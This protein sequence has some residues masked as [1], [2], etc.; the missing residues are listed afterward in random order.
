MASA[1]ASRDPSAKSLHVKVLSQLPEPHGV[2]QFSSLPASTTVAE[3]KTKIRDA[4]PSRPLAERQ[5]LIH[6]GR[7]AGRETDTLGEIF[8]KEAVQKEENHVFH[9]VIREVQHGANGSRQQQPLPQFYPN[10][11]QPPADLNGWQPQQ[12]LPTPFPVPTN[13]PSPNFGL[14]PPPN[15]NVQAPQSTSASRSG[16]PNALQQPAWPGISPAQMAQQ[17]MARL[18]QFQQMQQMQH[19]AA[20]QAQMQAGQ[21]ARAPTPLGQNGQSQNATSSHQQGLFA[22]SQSNRQQQP[23]RNAT[24]RPQT[25]NTENANGA[26]PT[27]A[28]ASGNMW[29][30]PAPQAPGQGMFM[31]PGMGGNFTR[32]AVGPNGQRVTMTI[33]STTNV[34]SMLPPGYSPVPQGLSGFMPP[35]ITVPMPPQ[36][37]GPPVPGFSPA[38]GPGAASAQRQPHSLSN[39]PGRPA[40]GTTNAFYGTAHAIESMRHYED[41]LRAVHDRIV[42]NPTDSNASR[43]AQASS[44]EIHLQNI[45]RLRNRAQTMINDLTIP[46]RASESARLTEEDVETLTNLNARFRRLI[47]ETQKAIDRLRG[48]LQTAQGSQGTDTQPISG[49]RGGSQS[50]STPQSS[51][52]TSSNSTQ[53]V[54][55]YLLYAPTGPHAV[56]LSPQG[57]FASGHPAPNNTLPQRGT[58]PSAT[59]APSSTTVGIAAINSEIDTQVARATAAVSN[60]NREIINANDAINLAH[61]AV[62]NLHEINNRNN[63]NNTQQSTSSGAGPQQQQQQPQANQPNGLVATPHPQQA[64]AEEDARD[65][66]RAIIYPLFRHLWLL[67]RLFGFIWFLTRGGGSRRTLLLVVATLIYCAIQ[68]GFLGDRWERFRQ[69]FEGLLGPPADNAQARQGNQQQAQQQDGA[70]QQQH[71]A[72]DADARPGEQQNQQ[73]AATPTPQDAAAR[74]LAQ[75]REQDRGWLRERLVSVERALV[76]FVASLYPGVGERHVAAQERARRQAQEEETRATRERERQA[77]EQPPPQATHDGSATGDGGEQVQG[78]IEPARED[79]KGKGKARAD[80]EGS[81]DEQGSSTGVQTGDASGSGGE[82]RARNQAAASTTTAASSSA[83]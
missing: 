60:I 30:L 76:L 69:H 54:T 52:P 35:Q 81:A 83:A 11:T 38:P 68:A 36:F 40:L 44:F 46:G 42:N 32:E 24:P 77:Q 17:Q 34:P 29:Q 61:A 39:F 82:M 59:Q 78:L 55:A 63:A 28:P 33:N 16:T 48:S 43:S 56:V 66:L 12:P 45:T 3:L 67:I 8:G 22:Q 4:I 57:P 65:I 18:N 6:R 49:E 25:P 15:L 72:S 19:A 5:R 53:P 37:S 7:V 73:A 47:A 2:L 21:Q 50:R 14:P 71:R 9:L 51:P 41:D 26:P 1:S 27:S 10:S 31:P 80:P 62:N 58:G 64:Q 23:E 74:L 75:R 79:A 70:Q 13:V 20:L